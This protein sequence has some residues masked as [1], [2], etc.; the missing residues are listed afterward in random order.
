MVR[1]I[2]LEKVA[3]N[4]ES[5]VREIQ[6]HRDQLVVVHGGKRVMAM[7]PIDFYDLW[8]AEREKAFKYFDKLSSHDMH[9]T[10]E[11]VESDVEQAIRETRSQDGNM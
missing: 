9:Y 2:A 7:I 6:D 1:E 8:F 5:A 10:N 11:E 4:L 3:L